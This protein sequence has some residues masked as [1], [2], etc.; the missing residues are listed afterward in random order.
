M[1]R[2][3]KKRNYRRRRYN[4]VASTRKIVKQVLT[5]EADKKHFLGSVDVDSGNPILGTGMQQP[6]CLI[7][8]G[9]ED[10]DRVGNDIKA[11]YLRMGGY[12]TQ[13]STQDRVTMVRLSIVQMKQVNGVSP[14][15][16]AIW[17]SDSPYSLRYTDMSSQFKILKQKT[18]KFVPID[19]YDQHLTGRH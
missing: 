18:Y 14:D 7:A 12:I 5:Q 4:R 1:P 16:T 6:L 17:N 9:T 8:Q 2:F 11:L 13:E 15:I 19:R 10:Y 3:A